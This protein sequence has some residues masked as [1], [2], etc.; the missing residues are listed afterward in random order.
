MLPIRDTIPG[1]NPPIGTWLVILANSVVFLFELMMPQPVLEQFV[2][3]C[4]ES[5]RPALPIPIGPSGSAFRSM[6]TGRS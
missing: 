1:R 4:S 5:C 6:T 2:H 3:R